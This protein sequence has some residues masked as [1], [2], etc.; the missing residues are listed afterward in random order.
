MVN[1]SMNRCEFDVCSSIRYKMTSLLDSLS[2]SIFG[3]FE[4][5]I[6][7]ALVNF[8]ARVDINNQKKLRAALG[9]SPNLAILEINFPWP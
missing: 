7:T 4:E 3:D 1:L 9:F 5:K 6:G 2:I 8:T